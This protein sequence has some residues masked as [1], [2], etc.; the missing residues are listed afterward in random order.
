LN[1]DVVDVLRFSI[2]GVQ[3][4]A[5]TA[6]SWFVLCDGVR[7]VNTN[8]SQGPCEEGGRCVIAVLRAVVTSIP[9]Y[10]VRQLCYFSP[11][12][13]PRQV[14]LHL[15][16]LFCTKIRMASGITTCPL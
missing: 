5:A 10:Q 13:F 7:K 8:R 9:R 11:L 16:A 12:F 6:F 2:S 15:V 3:L 4:A 14:R 1:L